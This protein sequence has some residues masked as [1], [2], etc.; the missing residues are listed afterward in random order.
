MAKKRMRIAELARESGVSRETIHY[1]LR[2]GLLPK[3]AK[4]GRTAAFYDDSHLERLR[5]IRQLRDEK[6]LPVAVIREILG[7]AGQHAHGRDLA[8]LAEVLAID[9][10]I[11]AG[12][13]QSVTPDEET[14][15]VALELGLLGPGVRHEPRH[16]EQIDPTQ[17]RVLAAVAEA[18][19]LE[20]EARGLTLADLRACGR[21][22]T[23]LV[24]IEAGLFFDLVFEIGDASR[25]VDALRR[26]RASVAHFVAAY[27]DLMLRRV[28]EEILH[29]VEHGPDLLAA[30]RT[31]P[32][33]SELRHRLGVER[34][35]RELSERARAGD[36]AAANDLVWH[37]FVLGQR[38]ELQRLP[39]RVHALLR[40]R[41]ELLT[42]HAS[43]S[44]SEPVSLE[45]ALARSGAFPLGEILV[46]ERALAQLVSV[47]PQ[48]DKGFLDEAVPAL[49]RLAHAAPEKDADPLASALAFLR[50]GLIGLALPRALG[51]QLGAQG[52][53][54]RALESVLG[55]PGRIEPALR[56]FVEGNARLSL[57]RALLLERPEL[58]RAQ[59]ERAHALDP[60]GPIGGA[61]SAALV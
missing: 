22:L 1:Y 43:T 44:G 55:V 26:G 15:R 3:P 37:L 33:G 19:A 59:L 53:L 18:L 35:T 12:R 51:R 56:V 30:A 45:Q 28:V 42:I 61:A 2:E 5:L 13:L 60:A 25:S 16:S 6:Y 11:S 31:L 20:G 49:H 40:P 46:A 58:A 48:K 41:A 32:L 38:T 52:D 10:T 54:E 17:A 34:R 21:E 57:G 14:L 50:R 39:K 29:A 7:A 47:G 24:E 27:R 4:T 9:P 36:L 23:R 8:A